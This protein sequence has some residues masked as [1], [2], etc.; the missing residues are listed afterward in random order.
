MKK[1]INRNWIII[2]I[3]ICGLFIVVFLPLA[4]RSNGFARALSYTLTG[5]AVI[6]IVYFV[7]AS[8]FS[9]PAFNPTEEIE[10]T[11]DASSS[12]DTGDKEE[13]SSSKD[14]KEES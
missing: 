1:L 14:T 5:V 6:W 4:S 10:E 7:R 2:T 9:G 12:K 13:A 3:V 11:R 8:I